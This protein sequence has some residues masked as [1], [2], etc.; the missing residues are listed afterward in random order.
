MRWAVSNQAEASKEA[1]QRIL[2]QE[3][4]P[5]SNFQVKIKEGGTLGRNEVSSV[6]RIKGFVEKGALLKLK[7][8]LVG[9]MSTVCSVR[10]ISF[11]L[12]KW[13]M[14][15]IKLQRIGGKSF[16]L[17]FEDD[18]L[19]MM[20]GNLNWSYLKEIFS[21]VELWPDSLEKSERATWIKVSGIPLQCSNHITLK[22]V[23]ELW[24]NFESL[25]E[26]ADHSI[27]CENITILITT[28]QDKRIDETMEIKIGNYIHL[29]QV[30]EIGISDDVGTLNQWGFKQKLN[31]G[32]NDHKVYFHLSSTEEDNSG[33]SSAKVERSRYS[34]LDIISTA[35]VKVSGPFLSRIVFCNFL[36]L[37]SSSPRVTLYFPIKECLESI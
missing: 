19:F 24:G 35:H 16:L 21:E 37:A 6:K 2:N 14:E 11:R 31:G 5:I 29:I 28:N 15:S 4:E 8:C 1:Y 25:G 9:K 18:E 36:L 7:R 13:G 22:R 17:S 34:V 10:E 32:S 26:N 30:L 20:L 27:K 12:Q 23:A 3:Q 33:A